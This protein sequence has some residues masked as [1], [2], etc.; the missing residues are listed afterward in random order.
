M[1]QGG[2]ITITLVLVLDIHEKSRHYN[3]I[4]K[5]ILGQLPIPIGGGP[6]L[7]AFYL[8]FYQFLPWNVVES[9]KRTIGS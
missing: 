1:G 9:D 5:C 6:L 3:S 2:I 8:N 7:L 4:C